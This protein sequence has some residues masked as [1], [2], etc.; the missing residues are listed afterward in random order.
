MVKGYKC[1]SGNKQFCFRRQSYP[2]P[3][4]HPTWKYFIPVGCNLSNCCVWE[5]GL[6]CAEKEMN[7]PLASTGRRKQ[8][9]LAGTTHLQPAVLCEVGVSPQPQFLAL[10][11]GCEICSGSLRQRAPCVARQP[12]SALK[13]HCKSLYFCTFYSL[14]HTERPF[15]ILSNGLWLLNVMNRFAL[16]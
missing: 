6:S 16:G 3:C 12:Y 14:V 2:S 11:S 4:S 8:Q 1:R 7:T 9:N 13:L 5:S 15:S 10:C